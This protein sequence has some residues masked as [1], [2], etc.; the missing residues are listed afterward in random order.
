MLDGD[1]RMPIAFIT[2]KNEKN[3]EITKVNFR[4][5]LFTSNGKLSY[6][7]K[8]LHYD[9]TVLG[10]SGFTGVSYYNNDYYFLILVKKFEG[11]IEN[12]AVLELKFDVDNEQIKFLNKKELIS[13]GP[14]NNVV[15]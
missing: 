5:I 4:Y 2:Q 1:D 3:E 14:E 10:Y 15:V 9:I 7:S 8:A 12:W 11:K 6:I 13:P